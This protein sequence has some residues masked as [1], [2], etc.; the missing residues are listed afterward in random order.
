MYKYESWDV[1][2]ILTLSRFG[3]TGKLTEDVPPATGDLA[4]VSISAWPRW[5]V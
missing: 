1:I 5:G 4:D 2:L 3:H